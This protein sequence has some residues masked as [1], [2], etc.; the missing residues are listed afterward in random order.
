MDL[1]AVAK[2]LFDLPRQING[3]GGRAHARTHAAIILRFALSQKVLQR[4]KSLCILH[5]LCAMI[6]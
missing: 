2:R 4:A 1:A 5:R 6:N 3:T